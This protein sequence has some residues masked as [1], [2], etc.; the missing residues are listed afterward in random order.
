MNKKIS[1]IIVNF[2]GGD[3]LISCIESLLN[4]NYQNYEIIIVD[5]NSSDN[6]I[7]LIKGN[8]DDRRVKILLEKKNHGFAKANNL[9][10]NI[11]NGELILLLNNDTYVENDFLIKMLSFYNEHNYDVIGPMEYSYDKKLKLDFYNTFDLIGYPYLS[12]NLK[13][14][15]YLVGFCLLFS[16]EFYLKTR[17]FD[18]SFFMYFEETDWFWRIKLLGYRFA[19]AKDINVYHAG[20]VQKN[21]NFKSLEW[22][23]KNNLVML[24][25]NYS[26]FTNLFIIPLFLI[27]NIF[28]MIFFILVL[29][30]KISFYY[31]ISWIEVIKDIKSI[32]RDRAWVQKNRVINDLVI[33]RHVYFGFSKLQHL[34][35]KFRFLFKK[36]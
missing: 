36:N 19:K 16:K 26:F 23:N 1:I 34:L 17:G 6:S 30:P 31:F 25:K 35:I 5:N 27:I 33:L 12:K 14:E 28:E 18:N 4:Q 7:S 10:I 15:M 9:G 24:I 3:Y 11:S 32:L 13:S 29:K 20:N 2:N 21:I 22:K 8:F